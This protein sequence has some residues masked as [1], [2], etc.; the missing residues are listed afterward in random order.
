MASC[1]LLVVICKLSGLS[2][3]STFARRCQSLSYVKSTIRLIATSLLAQLFFYV[4]VPFVSFVNLFRI[5]PL[6][7]HFIYLFF[8]YLFIYVVIFFFIYLF[9]S[10]SEPF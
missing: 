4:V 3:F 6:F 5:I 8:I 7:I 2:E 1:Q 9:I 10:L